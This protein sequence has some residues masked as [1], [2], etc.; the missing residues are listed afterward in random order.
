MVGLG[1]PG[2]EYERTRHNLG[3]VAVGLLAE[4]HGVRLRKARG[5][6]SLSAEVREG[7]RLLALAFPQTFMNESGAA[8]AALVRRHGVDDLRRLVVIHD[9]LDLPVGRVKLKLGGGTAG[10]N[11]LRSILAH[12]HDD[13]FARVRIGVGKP[14]SPD[15]G[16][17]YLLRQAAKAERPALQAAVALAAD[18]VEAILS[19]GLEAAMTR[20]NAE[21]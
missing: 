13:G 19:E 21:S 8:V 3:A 18:A 7:E 11:G 20:I 6:R 12:L 2:S 5:S 10:H 9:E 4:R 17:D 1:N 16:A 15:R 14:P